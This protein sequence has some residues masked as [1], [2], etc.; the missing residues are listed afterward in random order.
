[1]LMHTPLLL[2]AGNNSFIGRYVSLCS[3]SPPEL[4]MPVAE[5][6]IGYDV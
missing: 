3:L 2:K 6:V 4:G 1:M 5:G